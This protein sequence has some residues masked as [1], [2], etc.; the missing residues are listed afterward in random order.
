MSMLVQLKHF[1]IQ[2]PVDDHGLFLNLWPANIQNQS[3]QACPLMLKSP[4]LVEVLNIL[5]VVTSVKNGMNDFIDHC[6]ITV[7]I[8]KAT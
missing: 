5:N 3:N 8:S 7:C 4:M 1:S 2:G 6:G